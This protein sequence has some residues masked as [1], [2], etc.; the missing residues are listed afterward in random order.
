LLLL[1]YQR[2]ACPQLLG[3]FSLGLL[4]GCTT[5]PPTT[6]ANCIA[7]NDFEGLEG[8]VTVPP[9]LT[10]E[11]AH[12]GRYCVKVDLQSEYGL[13]YT[14]PLAKTG[15]RAGQRLRVQGWALRTGPQTG[16]AIVVQLTTAD[17]PTKKLLWEVLSISR[18]VIT[19]NRWVP[20]KQTFLLP[21][22]LPPDCQLSVYLWRHQ[23]TQPTY[24]DDLQL[25]RD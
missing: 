4:V 2:R 3:L 12:S 23:D 6:P 8:W 24:L 1:T 21:T 25:L 14:S 11:R 15:L 13:G 19:Y 17:Q 10:S 7:Q 22:T 18:Q 16:A 20:V 9:S 5:P